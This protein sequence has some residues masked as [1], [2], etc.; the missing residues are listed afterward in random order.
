M[1]VTADLSV[2]WLASDVDLNISSRADAWLDVD[3]WGPWDV[4][5]WG[6]WDVDGWGP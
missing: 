2:S 4:D 6:P 1:D 5:G 3:G